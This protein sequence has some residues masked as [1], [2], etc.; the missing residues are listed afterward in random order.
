MEIRNQWVPKCIKR[1][2]IQHLQ[3]LFASSQPNGRV[4]E[5]PNINVVSWFWAGER[6]RV[7]EQ[8][9]RRPWAWGAQE[10]CVLCG[11][12]VPRTLLTS[13][14]GRCLRSPRP[15]PRVLSLGEKAEQMAPWPVSLGVS[16]P[17]THPQGHQRV[18]CQGPSGMWRLGPPGSCASVVASWTSPHSR[19]DTGHSEPLVQA[20]FLKELGR[21]SYVAQWHLEPAGLWGSC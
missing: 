17:H 8:R 15:P 13:P 20:F 7:K 11:G 6:S 10:G 18:G 21:S 5:D 9:L 4:R 1:G 3:G 2:K 12:G 16:C 14:Q 19:L